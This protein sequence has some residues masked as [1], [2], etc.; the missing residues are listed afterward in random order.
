MLGEF[1]TGANLG[2][3]EPTALDLVY[4][5]HITVGRLWKR[6]GDVGHF[7]KDVAWHS[8]G[9]RLPMPEGIGWNAAFEFDEVRV[10]ADLKAG[11]E[12]SGEQRQ[13]FALELRAASI[14]RGPLF[15]QPDFGWYSRAHGL[16]ND[17][18]DDLTTEDAQRGHWLR[19]D[20]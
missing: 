6:Y 5:N 4:V 14:G 19:T 8:D 2:R 9:R 7:M 20:T 15:N 11:K 13:I 12:S 16:L 1:L 18:F 10:T 17:T 3:F